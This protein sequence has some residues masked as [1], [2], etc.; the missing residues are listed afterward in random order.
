MPNAS[1]WVLSAEILHLP[2]MQASNT[3]DANENGIFVLT[4]V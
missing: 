4:V 1:T 2:G 3:V